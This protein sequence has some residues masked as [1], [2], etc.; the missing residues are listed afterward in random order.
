MNFRNQ[1]TIITINAEEM[2]AKVRKFSSINA[3]KKHNRLELGG[4]AQR[5]KPSLVGYTVIHS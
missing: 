2:T 4:T 3:A 5:G 1:N